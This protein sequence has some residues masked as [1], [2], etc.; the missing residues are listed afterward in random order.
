MNDI[1]F[2][3]GFAFGAVT[4]MVGYFIGQARG[5]YESSPYR[6]IDPIRRPRF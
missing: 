2:L 6:D 1:F 5:K 4:F 3:L